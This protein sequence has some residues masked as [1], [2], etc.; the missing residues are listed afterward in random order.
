MG[1][2]GHTCHP[3]TPRRW[4][5][6]IRFI[7]PDRGRREHESETGRSRS[8]E[9]IERLSRRSVG[10]R[11][12]VTAATADKISKKNRLQGRRRGT[13]VLAL[14]LLAQAMMRRI[15]G[16]PALPTGKR[17]LPMGDTHY[18]DT[19]QVLVEESQNTPL[20]AFI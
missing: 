18:S 11:G 10:W 19:R 16:K 1:L 12:R 9:F 4:P 5:D 15:D 14:H 20:C 3:V 13:L 2:N 17:S 8:G 7:P 6:L